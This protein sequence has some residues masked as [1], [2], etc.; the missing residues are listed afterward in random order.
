LLVN[1]RLELDAREVIIRELFFADEHVLQSILAD[2]SQGIAFIQKILASA[3]VS[4]EEKIR[5]ADRVRGVLARMNEVQ[6]NTMSYKRLLDELA[7]IP[8]GLTIGSNF[9]K[10]DPQDVVSPLTPHST[11]FSG[12]SSHIHS[13]LFMNHGIHSGLS[14][15]APNTA[16]LSSPFISYGLNS[17]GE[18]TLF[19]NYRRRSNLDSDH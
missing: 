4:A 18:D 14:N 2:Q 1:Q 16:A 12:P 7:S 10:I 3:C 9:D 19:N 13:S 8:S 17:S 5:L 6:D 15:S 11:F